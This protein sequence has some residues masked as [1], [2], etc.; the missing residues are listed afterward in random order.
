MGLTRLKA[1]YQAR[2]CSLASIAL[3][4]I[5][6]SLS[7]WPIFKAMTAQVSN[8]INLTWILPSPPS[9]PKD[10]WGLHCA[11]LDNPK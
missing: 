3:E 10:F 9:E 11:H 4:D 8:H 7:L 5:S 6:L 2:I 1:R